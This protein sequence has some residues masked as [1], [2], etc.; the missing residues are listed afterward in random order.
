MSIKQTS[1][2]QKQNCFTSSPLHPTPVTRPCILH[3]WYTPASYTMAHPCILH[4][5]LTCVLHPCILHP[6][7]HQG[8]LQPWPTPA[9]YIHGPPLHPTPMAHPCILHPPP[10]HAFDN[11]GPALHPT[12]MAHPCVLHQGHLCILHPWPIPASY[13]M[14][15]C[16]Y[17]DVYV[18]HENYSGKGKYELN[19][20]FFYYFLY[21]WFFLFYRMPQEIRMI[22]WLTESTNITLFSEIHLTLWKHH[23]YRCHTDK[24]LAPVSL[25]NY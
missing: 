7:P 17:F 20:C 3:P 9:S 2:W 6:C 4:L 14:T 25:L 8:I 1:N 12:P 15:T 16:N 13:T 5:W 22:V 23:C 11:H 24:F 19:L 10:T 21:I 18:P